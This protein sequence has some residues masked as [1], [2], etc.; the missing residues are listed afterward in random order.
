[1]KQIIQTNDFTYFVLELTENE[2]YIVADIVR[3]FCLDNNMELEFY[4]TL[5]P[6]IPLM[7]EVK[8]KGDKHKILEFLIDEGLVENIKERRQ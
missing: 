4:T 6:H 7:R 5:N 8:I 3:T 2:H 1:M